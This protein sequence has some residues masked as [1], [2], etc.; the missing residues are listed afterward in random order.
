LNIFLP[1]MI[2]YLTTETDKMTQL[3]S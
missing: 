2:S 1:A 3:F